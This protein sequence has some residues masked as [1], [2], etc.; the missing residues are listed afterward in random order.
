MVAYNCR[1]GMHCSDMYCIVL[2]RASYG[3]AFRDVC[4]H[5]VGYCILHLCCAD[6]DLEMHSIE[7]SVLFFVSVAEGC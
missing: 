3:F 6:G 5:K 1:L 2:V 7:Y 4:I